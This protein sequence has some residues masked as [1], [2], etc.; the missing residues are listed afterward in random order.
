MKNTVLF[1]PKSRQI[2][3]AIF[4]LSLLVAVVFG[5][6]TYAIVRISDTNLDGRVTQVTGTCTDFDEEGLYVKVNGEVK[7]YKDGP[8][9]TT[10]VK[11]NIANED[12][13]DDY[14]K[15][16]VGKEVS[17]CIP[18]NPYDDKI[19]WML[20]LTVDGVVVATTEEVF[21]HEEEE[22][23]TI[24]IV[25]TTLIA[26]C[27]AAA[28]VSMILR[29]NTPA[30]KEYDLTQKFAEHFADRQPLLKQVRLSVIFVIALCVPVVAFTIVGIC[31]EVV[32]NFDNLIFLYVLAATAI[33]AIT[34]VIPCV[35]I[36]NKNNDKY[37]AD[38]F[39]FDFSDA[40]NYPLIR[41][42]DRAEFQKALDKFKAENPDTYA[43]GGNLY[44]VKF[45]DNCLQ[46]FDA[47]LDEDEE[48]DNT[49]EDIFAESPRPQTPV[50]TI[51]Y[52]KLNWQAVPFYGLSHR[53]LTV[54]IRS[55]LQPDSSFP[56]QFT[57]DIH[58]LLEKDLV[59]SLHKFNV[60]VE[61]LEEILQNKAELLKQHRHKG[62]TRN[63]L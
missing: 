46:M 17:F 11:N 13:V 12:N 22:N 61:G 23:R 44:S 59:E 32:Q 40:D 51:D 25:F 31:S 8:L 45:T 16:L 49:L 29:V 50:F 38:K 7:A 5:I 21:A 10:L 3:K 9:H 1:P 60:Q 14:F 20:S 54:V 58:L 55:R 53:P 43:D 63:A 41:K 36:A 15:S 30:L 33:V 56:E 27:A 62:N 42:K 39:P 18:Q 26:V 4:C 6:A 48:A 52:A 57:N 2:F 19:L 35:A 24:R 37:Y 34:T 28:C 47:I